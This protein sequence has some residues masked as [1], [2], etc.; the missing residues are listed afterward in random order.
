[1]FPKFL[2]QEPVDGQLIEHGVIAVLWKMQSHL[3]PRVLDYALVDI[4]VRARC[5][6]GF[7]RGSKNWNY[8]RHA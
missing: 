1:M 7:G 5:V 8:E 3:C 2:E 4:S 6:N